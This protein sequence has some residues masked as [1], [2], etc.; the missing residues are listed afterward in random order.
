MNYDK[1]IMD[2]VAEMR[3]VTDFLLSTGIT[4]LQALS[5]LDV[6]QI[7]KPNALFVRDQ[8]PHED[9]IMSQSQRELWSALKVRLHG[10]TYSISIPTTTYPIVLTSPMRFLITSL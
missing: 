9:K 2:P 6:L 3:K 5:E 7:F 10:S 4:R 8:Y 1:L